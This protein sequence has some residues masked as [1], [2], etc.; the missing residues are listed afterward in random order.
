MTNSI[1]TMWLRCIK[2]Y[3]NKIRNQ[4]E[5]RWIQMK[6]L[7]VYQ[8]PQQQ[9]NGGNWNNN[10]YN[11]GG[12]RRLPNN[13]QDGGR[14][15]GYRGDH[16]NANSTQKAY[17]NAIKKQIQLLCC[18]S[19]GYNVDH[20]GYKGPPSCQKQ[21]H[22][23]NVKRDEAH[24]YEGACMRLQHKTLPDG[25]GAGRGW[26]MTKQMEKG[27]FVMDKQAA[28]KAQQQTGQ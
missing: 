28:W 12:Q 1:S 8:Q 23:P 3:M 5:C 21:I 13:Y 16:R 17:S 19:R 20:D 25:T 27:R 6:I 11:R 9:S 15:G 7:P 10:E 22:L 2:Q 26:I 4:S 24:M 18:F 14:G